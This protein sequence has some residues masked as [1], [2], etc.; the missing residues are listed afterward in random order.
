MINMVNFIEIRDITNKYFREAMKIYNDSFPSNERHP[1]NKIRKL[2]E[3]SRY[4]MFVGCLERKI[5]FMA[6]LYSLKGPNFILLDYMATHRH[7]RKLGIGNKFIETIKKTNSNNHI[8][9]EVE[10]PDYDNNKAQKEQRIDFYKGCGFKEMKNVRYVLPPLS[11][12]TATEMNL[13]ILPIKN[14][15]KID[16][17]IIKK[18]VISIYEEIYDRYRDDKFLN[19]FI[20]DIDPKID[21]L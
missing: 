12:N 8:I 3:E 16:G 9:I 6:L 20:H 14:I 19:S 5:V 21:L 18:I 13:M 2:L 11:R 10:N 7:F 15:D 4:Q 17:E 1:V